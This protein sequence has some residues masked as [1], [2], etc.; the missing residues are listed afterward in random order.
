MG[1]FGGLSC[2]RSLLIGTDN[3][4][5]LSSNPRLLLPRFKT[6]S[7]SR[8]RDYVEQAAS[9]RLPEGQAG[10]SA[11]GFVPLS[12]T[13]EMFRT[14]RQHHPSGSESSWWAWSVRR[15]AV[16]LLAI[17][18]AFSASSAPSRA[19]IIF[20]TGKSTGDLIRYDSQDPVG[21]RT[22]L[23][24]GTL[25]A[26]SALAI[27]PDGNLYIGNAGNGTTIAPSIVRLSVGTG[28]FTT[29]HTFSSYDI[30]PGSMV[31]Q[32][33]ALLVGRDP[34]SG[35]AGPV[36]RLTNVTGGTVTVSNYTSGGNLVSSP[37]L[38]IAPDGR[39]YVSDQTWN[40]LSLVASGPVKRFDASGAFVDEVIADGA[41]GLQ[42]PAGMVIGGNQLF[43]ASYM[44]GGVLATSLVSGATTSFASA[45][46]PFE[47][48]AL[49]LL[50]DGSLLA[51]SGV[52]GSI[53]RF[54]SGGA[55]LE[56]FATDIGPIGGLAAVV[57][58][59]PSECPNEPGA[60]SIFV[61]V[62]SDGDD[63]CS[64]ASGG[65]DCDDG[66]ND[67]YPGAP[68]LCGNVGFNNDC[69]NAGASD[70]QTPFVLHRDVDGDGY[71]DV[72]VFHPQFVIDCASNWPGY[73]NDRNDCNDNDRYVN[74]SAA[75]ICDGIDNNCSNSI[76]ENQSNIDYYADTDDD[77]FGAGARVGSFCSEAAAR[78]RLSNPTG[79]Y[80]TTS[81][82]CGAS[83]SAVYPGAPENCANLG[84][85]NDCDGYN[86]ETEVIAAGAGDLQ[87]FYADADGDGYGS[88]SDTTG[89]PFCSRP[90]GRS[91]TNNDCNDTYGAGAPI[92]PG[93]A[94]TCNGIDDDCDGTADDGLP[95]S[96]YYV[97]GDDDGYGTGTS[98]GSY[99]SEAAA[100]VRLGNPSGNYST[101]STD[102]ADGDAA[103]NPSAAETCNGIDDDCD[104]SPDDGLP[105]SAYYV[106]GDDDGYGTGTSLGSYCSEAAARVRLGNP[107]GNYSTASTDCD[108]A[109]AAARPGL[110]EICADYG[111]D[112]NC[113][114]DR[115]DYDNTAPDLIRFHQDLD[116][117]GYGVAGGFSVE[118]CETP[119]PANRWA[120]RT[121][122]CN[123]SYA[124]ISPLGAEVC[125]SYSTARDEDCDG[126]ADDLDTAGGASGKVDYFTDTDG[127]GYGT[128]S[129][130]SRCDQ[131]AS[132]SA[133]AGDCN[134]SYAYIS[135]VGTEVCDSYSTAR[136][137]DCDGYADDLDAQ[138]SS[139]GN[140]ST[141]YRD[142]DSDGYGALNVT[143]ERCDAG[144]GSDGYSY[145]AN[146]TD[147]DDTNAARDP[148]NTEICD[149]SNLDEDCDGYADDLDTVGGASGKVTYYVDGDSDGYG[150]GAGTDYCDPPVNTSTIAGDCNDSYA[151]IS[152]VGTEVCDSYGTA[153]DEDC[154]GY[155]D[156]A[157]PQAS[158][159]GNRSTW[160]RD[161]DND[162]YG[163]AS[164]T[165]LRCD[166]GTGSDGYSYIANSADCDDTTA[167]R[168][169]GN[170]EVCDGL[171]VDEDCDGYAD[172]ADPQASSIG[173]R[174]TWYRD[175]DNDGYGVLGVTAQ[176]CDAGTGSDGYSYIAN[177]TDCDDTTATRDPG[178][179]EVCD[180]SNLDEDCDGY[181]D[182]LDVGG[183][184]GK[185]P[186][187]TDIDGDGYGVTTS[188]VGTF[189]DGGASRSALAGDCNDAY[190][191]ISPAGT[192]V[193]DS[194]SPARDEDCD[195]LS[196]N[197]DPSALDSGKSNFYLDGD[198]DGYGAG[199]AERFCDLPAKYSSNPD[200]CN[201]TNAGISPGDA[202]ITAD[203]IDQNCDGSEICFEDLDSDGYR[204]GITRVSV[205][206]DCDD[207]LEALD[208]DPGGDCDDAYSY[209]SPAGAEACDAYTPARDEDCDNLTDDADLGGASGKV[210]YFADS[211]SFDS[212]RPGQSVVDTFTYTIR[213]SFGALSTATVSVTVTGANEGLTIIGTRRGDLNLN[214]TEGN[215]VI[216]GRQGGDV[217]DGRGGADRIFG[218]QGHDK[219]YG[220][221]GNDE[222]QGGNGRDT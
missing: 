5:F 192:E 211:D 208:S 22:V 110:P 47:A 37:G 156:D 152:P 74:P 186:Y 133:F 114:G 187:Y 6:T 80:S 69:D 102:C 23:A 31:F 222:V 121:G 73:V 197:A 103:R 171:D 140:R 99:C 196:D 89:S 220:G 3:G 106:D 116:G 8:A 105:S 1:R 138:A 168:D 199:N 24:S 61:G 119:E 205:D 15:L 67:V 194:Y 195:G 104:S 111:T 142:S 98:L 96:D 124:Y 136:D 28:T 49:T 134:D 218:G 163:T 57:P 18:G 29:V 32:G 158:S 65:T 155:A 212:L 56:T 97:D 210:T 94:E 60:A 85:N 38:A 83:D 30:V 203:G 173:N 148:G 130:Q 91:A 35:N 115:Y 10:R 71:G 42:G 153:R 137:E 44:N 221:A 202:E 88:Q 39:L 127:D 169:P 176:R 59:G 120:T 48:R 78:V 219:L 2:S 165:D 126:Y 36:V 183:A 109:S 70:D 193:C 16:G 213:D 178:N 92:N 161:S 64:T 189:C 143:A 100:R 123:D 62:D 154:D 182:D 20:A 157:D 82:D 75:E 172:D 93:A 164:V 188:V 206:S 151:Y 26:P 144:T 41:S 108:D 180:S 21:T 72:N 198:R 135:P 145:I 55:L 87:T 191:Y 209:I 40:L 54:G 107:S 184:S 141:W 25:S 132:T 81:D 200:D 14:P 217:V 177:S 190:T 90:S 52:D 46:A 95:S 112:N 162:G 125:D 118:A 77:G 216:Y 131:P 149:G 214:G 13:P 43:T 122:D 17:S 19:D 201:D 4:T 139:I 215:D 129:A 66:A 113:D 86:D 51:G 166:A 185:V 175:S 174:S 68:E 204:T 7:V 50:A 160:Y 9:V 76:D 11:G 179:A 181:A 58:N 117:D 33:S 207:L 128:G 12:R 150:A 159:I 45:G 147:C 146:S 63:Y 101:R 170:E 167:T 34:D 79:N 27:G 84:T 53:R